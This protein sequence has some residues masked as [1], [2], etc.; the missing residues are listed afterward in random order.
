MSKPKGEEKARNGPAR[1]RD[2]PSVHRGDRDVALA[3]PSRILYFKAFLFSISYSIFICIH[4]GSV[5]LW[6]G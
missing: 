2:E 6:L 1:V 4:G 5:P 3:S